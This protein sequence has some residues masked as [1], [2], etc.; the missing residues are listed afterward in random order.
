M[1][2]CDG[3]VLLELQALTSVS[4]PDTY[5]R[6]VSKRLGVS[7][8]EGF[9]SIEHLHDL[10]CTIASPTHIQGFPGLTAKARLLLA[11]VRD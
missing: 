8:D 7:E 6:H 11:V 3:R 4:A 9:F 2:L 1:S 5:P 10:G